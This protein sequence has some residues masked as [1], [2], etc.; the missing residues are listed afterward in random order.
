MVIT[1]KHIVTIQLVITTVQ[2]MEQRYVFLDM[3]IQISIAPQVGHKKQM[4]IA[5]LLMFQ[6]SCVISNTL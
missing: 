4:F 1:V 2:S 3:P 5:V 6:P